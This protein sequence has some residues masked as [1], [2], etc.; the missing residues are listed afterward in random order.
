VE[1]SKGVEDYEDI[2][3]MLFDLGVVPVGGNIG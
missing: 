2:K 3:K 1:L